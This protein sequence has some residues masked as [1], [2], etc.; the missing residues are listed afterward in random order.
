M[1][2]NQD[3]KRRPARNMKDDSHM[4][5]DQR[6]HAGSEFFMGGSLEG[7]DYYGASPDFGLPREGL[8][9]NAYPAPEDNPPETWSKPNP[10]GSPPD[11]NRTPPK[12]SD[13]FPGKG[14]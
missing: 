1:P 6:A 9:A 5:P 14:W 2:G 12:R 11:D 10:E 7:D 8:V 3:Q 4:A 13:A